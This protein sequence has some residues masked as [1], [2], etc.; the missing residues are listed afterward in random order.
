MRN[1]IFILFFFVNT[2]FL[3]A[4][5]NIVYLDVQ[6]IVDNSD[7]GIYLKK[8]V[9]NTQEKIKL[10]LTI[11]E[12]LIKDKETDIKNKKNILKK[13]EIDKNLNELNELIKKYQIFR[14]DSSKLILDEKNKYRTQIL[15]LLN[16]IISNFANNNNIT[17]I[18]EKKNILLGAKV[19][20]V[21]SNI[22]TILNKETKEKKL[23]NEN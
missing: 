8:K 13:D 21:T 10:E 6:Y 20:D 12:K 15:E 14:K 18:L 5:N 2:Q 3:Y 7:I 1:F 9:S 17:L 22:L 23:I 16:P 4:S 11:K 19:L